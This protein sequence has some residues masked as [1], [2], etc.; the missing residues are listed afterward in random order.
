MREGLGVSHS[1]ASAAG[2]GAAWWNTRA[3]GKVDFYW[4]ADSVPNNR[5]SDLSVA[6]ETSALKTK[7]LPRVVANIAVRPLV[8]GHPT[9]SPSGAG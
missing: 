9:I 2:R 8:V 7:D 5:D 1:G 4:Q 3:M 6:R